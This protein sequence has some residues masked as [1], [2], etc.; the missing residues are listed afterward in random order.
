MSDEELEEIR[1]TIGFVPQTVHEAMYE[2]NVGRL[3]AEVERL[4]LIE[5]SARRLCAVIDDVDRIGE[6]IEAI[7]EMRRVLGMEVER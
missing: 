3:L 2:Q 7:D 1:E 6:Q 5:R 4:R